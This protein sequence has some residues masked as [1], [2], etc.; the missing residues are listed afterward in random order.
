LENR[1]QLEY[2]NDGVPENWSTGVMEYWSIGFLKSF[3]F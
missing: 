1:Y 2:W 3:D